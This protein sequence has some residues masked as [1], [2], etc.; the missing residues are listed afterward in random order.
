MAGQG[1][2]GQGNH[3]S[4]GSV[5][6]AVAVAA[7]KKELY[8]VMQGHPEVTHGATVH[9]MARSSPPNYAGSMRYLGAKRTQDVNID[10][11]N[12]AANEKRLEDAA[13]YC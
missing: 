13:A 5:Q 8:T 6:Q 4:S 10:S 7:V 9:R 11:D 3:A 1:R 12:A 2:W